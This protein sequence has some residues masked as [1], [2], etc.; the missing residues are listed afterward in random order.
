MLNSLILKVKRA[1]SPVFGFARKAYRG[2]NTVS[3]PVPGPLKP[4]GRAIYHVYGFTWAAWK[5]VVSACFHEPVFRSR[6]E[7]AG[8]RLNLALM[9]E[10]FDHTRIYIGDDVTCHGKLG[11]YS[12]RVFDEPT[13]IIGNRVS[14]GHQMNISCNREVVIGDDVLIAG[15][16]TISDNDGH[17]LDAQKR[18]SG[19]PA[20]AESTRPVHIGN[21]AWIGAG[22]VILKGVTIGEGAI[23]GAGSIVTTSVPPY[24]VVAG[25]PARVVKTLTP[26]AAEFPTAAPV[27]DR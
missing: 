21:M 15:N 12:G 9:P 1:D 11:I 18:I 26:Q 23:V 7:R 17:P 2:L 5:R 24:T 27:P 22:V 4:A 3:V 6:C 14:I 8:K 25:N 16:C 20:S 19:M 10:A 13:L